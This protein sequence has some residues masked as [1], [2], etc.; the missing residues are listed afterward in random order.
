MAIEN[1]KKHF[2]WVR[3]K[4]PGDNDPASALFALATVIARAANCPQDFGGTTPYKNKILTAELEW[5]IGILE[6]NRFVYH[7]MVVETQEKVSGEDRLKLETY[8]EGK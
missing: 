2:D 6:S 3:S 1:F 5:R 4:V 7:G 8:M